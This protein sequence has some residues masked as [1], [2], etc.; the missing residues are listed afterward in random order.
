[1]VDVGPALVRVRNLSIVTAL[2]ANPIV[3]DISFD[4]RRGEVL[5]LIGESGSG[6]TS[7]ALA[8]MAYAKPGLRIASG[9]VEVAGRQI[10]SLSA[11]ECRGVRGNRICYVPQ[12][13]AAAFNPARTIM[14]QVIESALVHKSGS[15]RDLEAK[16]VE[17]FRSLALPDP[18]RVGAR[19]PHQVSGGQLQRLAAAMALISDPDL[20]IFDEPTTAL[21]VT[22]QIEVLRSFKAAIKSRDT[23]GVYVTHDL[24]VV[25]QIADR[26][27][28]LRGGVVQDAGETGAILNDSVQEYTT[29]LLRAAVHEARVE[30]PGRQLA[31][32]P[33]PVLQAEGLV[34][35]YGPVGA[36]GDPA[37]TVLKDIGFTLHKGQNLG[38]IGESGSGK[39]SLT[40]VV[41]GLLAPARGA[42][43][44]RGEKLAPV[45]ASRTR[46]QLRDIQIVFQSADTALNPSH[47]V[48]QTLNRVL[49]FYH[50]MGA[51]SRRK[52][53]AE[54]LDLVQLP[55]AAAGRLPSELSGGQKQRVNLARALAAE[56]A[57]ILCDEVTSALDTV[58]GAAILDLLRELGRD[59]DLSLVF[60]SHDLSVVRSLCDEVI[61]LYAGQQVEQTAV[62]TLAQN[63][64]RHPYTDL[65][66]ASVPELRVDWLQD[67][68]PQFERDDALHASIEGCKFYPRCP[69]GRTGLCDVTPPPERLLAA[70]NLVRCHMPN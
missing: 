26:I 40:R 13:A 65:L 21:D 60:I 48:G 22:T 25:A 43:R 18:A 3:R 5:A 11:A 24:P 2:E 7:I 8:L 52:R 56:P 19:Y 62:E 20:V 37:F 30:A 33:I 47:T 63:N 49:S 9:T 69:R 42:V 57:V 34:A 66:L 1:M 32:R 64:V 41:A 54:L 59:L 10:L 70:G 51:D 15:R 46:Q 58:V 50:G 4:V 35:G 16:A 61:V 38:V 44:F 12:S 31:V 6:K 67:V 29:S 53:T 28:V 55:A 68:G 39:S 36:G 23:T 17:I 27:V 45:A 14:S